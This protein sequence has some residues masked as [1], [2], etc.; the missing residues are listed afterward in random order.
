MSRDYISSADWRSI[1]GSLARGIDIDIAVEAQPEREWSPSGRQSMFIP[2]K[3]KVSVTICEIGAGR[4][5][6]NL[7]RLVDERDE[8]RARVMVLETALAKVKQAM[9]V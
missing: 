8:L 7:A 1:A 9:T 6:R 5:G 2:E 4:L 3:P